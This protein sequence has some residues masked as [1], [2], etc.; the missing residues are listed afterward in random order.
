MKPLVL[1]E[2]GQV[3]RWHAQPQMN[4]RLQTDADH[5]WGVIAIVYGITGGTASRSLLLNAAF[6]DVGE[7]FAGDPPA[8]FKIAFPDV[9][10]LHKKAEASFS[11][12]IVGLLPE[13]SDE[14]KLILKAADT[15]EAIICILTYANRPAEVEGWDRALRGLQ[16]IASEVNDVYEFCRAYVNPLIS[17]HLGQNETIAPF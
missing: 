12:D 4:R 10:A 6:H 15:I 13:L 11:K 7:R 16:A 5:Q 2:A 14:E 17:L 3:L 8:D 9:A 1:L